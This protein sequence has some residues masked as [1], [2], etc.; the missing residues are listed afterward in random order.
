MVTIT[1]KEF[2]DTVRDLIIIHFGR[3]LQNDPSYWDA[4][5]MV[6]T[7]G[8]ETAAL[9]VFFNEFAGHLAEWGE[10]EGDDHRFFRILSPEAFGIAN[11]LFN[12]LD[13]GLFSGSGPRGLWA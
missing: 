5:R 9:F 12:E 1:D 11:A 4:R 2:A 8:E 13:R 6:E 10:C 3:M 7:A